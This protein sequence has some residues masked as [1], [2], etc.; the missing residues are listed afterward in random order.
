[1]INLALA[2]FLAYTGVLVAIGLWSFRLMEKVPIA[3]YEEEFYSAGRGLGGVLVALVIASGMAS[4]GTFIAGPGMCYAYGYSWVLMNVMQSFISLMLLG[5]VGIM[6]GL[7]ARRVNVV[8]YLDL[9]QARYRDRTLVLVMGGLVTL[10]LI[11]YMAT[12]FVGAARVIVQMTGVSYPAALALGSGVVVVYCV[13]GGMHG[14][15]VATLLQGIVITVGTILLFAGTLKAAGGFARSTQAIAALDVRLL[16]PTSFGAFPWTFVFSVACLGGYLAAGAPHGMLAALTYKNTTALKRGIWLGSILLFVWTLLL[17][18]SGVMGR[19]IVSDLAVADEIAP[20]LAMKVLPGPLAGLVLAGVVAGIQTTVAAMA[21][22][23]TSC[24]ARNV[25][26]E[27]GIQLTPQQTKTL[28]RAT[29]IACLGASVVLALTQP[30]LVQWI[31]LFALGGIAVSAFAPIVVGLHWKR[32]N[33]WGA[34][35]AVGGGMTLY[36][37]AF[38]VA[39]Q[40]GL[41]GMHPSLPCTAVAVALYVLVSLA[42]PPPPEDV[43]RT[44]WG[45]AAGADSAQRPSEG[46]AARPA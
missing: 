26:Q 12:Q 19:A 16:S 27:L 5:A 23:I 44:F 2:S 14:A 28:S 34:L 32:G 37:L 41:L 30:P 1:V 15:A 17:C 8:T 3:K 35:A 38:T 7:V 21:I 31:I 46:R 36:V 20:W 29:M 25:V 6:V 42:T 33:R 45:R 18:L 22:V 24:V 43:L 39:P 13:L 4:A 11:P 9:F 40:I 10:L